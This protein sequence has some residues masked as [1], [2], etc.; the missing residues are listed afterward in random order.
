MHIVAGDIGGGDRDVKPVLREILPVNPRLRI[1]ASPWSA[2]PWMKTNRAF[3]GGRLRPECEGVYAAYLAR[4]LRTISGASRSATR[5]CTASS[6]RPPCC[7]ES[8][9][10]RSVGPLH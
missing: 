9:R 8:A 5:P 4:Y 10:R 3:V 7:R 6:R 2:P 1:I